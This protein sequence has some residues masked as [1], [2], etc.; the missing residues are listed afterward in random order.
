MVVWRSVPAAAE[1]WE[2]SLKSQ[3]WARDGKEVSGNQDRFQK[4]EEA[5][6]VKA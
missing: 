2:R 1:G 3:Q 4:N 5:T 6:Q